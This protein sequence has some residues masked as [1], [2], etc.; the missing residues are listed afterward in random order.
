MSLTRYRSHKE[1]EAGRIVGITP[2]SDESPD[3]FPGSLTVEGEGRID[4]TRA[5]LEKHNPHLGGYFVRYADGYESFSPA[6]AFEAGYRAAWR[7][8]D[9]SRLVRHGDDF[10]PGDFRR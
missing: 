6:E 8:G 9:R 5:Y 1:V 7:H 4:V 2:A 3:S 10:L